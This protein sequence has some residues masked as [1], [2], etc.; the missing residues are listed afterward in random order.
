MPGVK[1]LSPTHALHNLLVGLS[2]LTLH[3]RGP[4][5]AIS[6]GIWL[7]A[8]VAANVPRV[9]NYNP[10]VW[11][12]MVHLLWMAPL[13]IG[14]IDGMPIWIGFF[15]PALHHPLVWPPGQGGVS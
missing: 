3:I 9:R 4:W 15:H 6:L 5:I 1:A 2:Q 11:F 8:V 14:I 13:S 10:K 7:M 12:W